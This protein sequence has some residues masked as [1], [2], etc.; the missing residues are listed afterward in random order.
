MP[1]TSHSPLLLPCLLIRRSLRHES[2]P[3]SRR[4]YTEHMWAYLAAPVLMLLPER[5]R[6]NAGFAA[7]MPWCVASFTCGVA[8]AVSGLAALVWW[9]SYSVE[10][11]A[12]NVMTHAVETQSAVAG[13]GPHEFGVLAL[14]VV[15]AS[16]VTWLIVVW[17]VEGIVRV[18]AAAVTEEVFATL[19]LALIAGVSALVQPVRNENPGLRASTAASL[20][21]T[22]ARSFAA[23]L[24]RRAFEKT[25][26]RIADDVTRIQGVEGDVLRI[27]ANHGK[28]DWEVGRMIRIGDDF[29]RLENV[30]ERHGGAART[31]AHGNDGLPSTRP[32]STT[33]SQTPADKH[34]RPFVYKLRRLAAGIA[35]RHTLS[36][37]LP[38]GAAAALESK[39]TRAHEPASVMARK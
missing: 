22:P 13:L 15:A 3:A 23:F 35:T 12:Q 9:Y 18:L 10:N 24:R 16:P 39:P 31:S 25:H 27:R 5:W 32:T 2:A 8:Q 38:P 29:Y 36:Y 28:P 6:Q 11:W 4:I 21:D 14:T 34:A 30:S 20:D 7:P 26:A 37:D 17:S 1:F 33:P 19:P